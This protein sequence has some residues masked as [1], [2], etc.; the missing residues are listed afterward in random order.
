MYAGAWLLLLLFCA[1]YLGFCFAL[2]GLVTSDTCWLLALGRLMYQT[3][4]VPQSDPLSFTLPLAA[5]VGMPLPFILHQW[6]FEVLLYGLFLVGKLHALIAVC[7]AA[8]AMAF[9]SVP[10]VICARANA[11]KCFV[12]AILPLAAFSGAIRATVRPEVCT[13]LFLALLLLTLQTMRIDAQ[14]ERTKPASAGR[15]RWELIIAAAAIEIIW[16]NCHSGFVLGLG[17]MLVY[18]LSFLTQDVIDKKAIGPATK[19]G[20]LAL[21]TA[22]L[23]T[24]VNP[25]GV[26]L[27]M[28]M[29]YLLF[30]S[31]GQG[32]TEMKHLEAADF[33]RVVLYPFFALLVLAFVAIAKSVRR[34]RAHDVGST[35][36]VALSWKSP[37]PM[38]SIILIC[39]ASFEALNC[40]RLIPVMA[41]LL[42]SESTA[43]VGNTDSTKGPEVAAGETT[44]AE[45]DNGGDFLL[46]GLF[47][48]WSETARRNLWLAT[49]ALP[50]VVATL[51]ALL[52]AGKVSSLSLPQPS[53]FFN[54]P[55]RAI[56]FLRQHPPQGP[57]FNEAKIGSMIT[58]YLPERK[59]FLDTRF[60]EYGPMLLADY[61]RILYAQDNCLPTLDQYGIDWVFVTPQAPIAVTLEHV[62]GW[63]RV[64]SDNDAVIFVR[65]DQE[66]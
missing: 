65:K 6:L 63:Q 38:A 52:F 50:P 42:L 19:T 21:V 12:Y 8:L 29:P 54:P 45:D 25:A 39:A 13:C 7:S 36:G 32:I 61:N 31:I 62:G 44:A 27:W 48:G 47:R 34:Q 40:M 49:I 11:P 43:L 16:C 23:V 24:L 59:V 64:Y 28:F 14:K 5:A 3:H 56:E 60:D 51:S 35:D 53:E 30:S 22:T 41:L 18:A 46:V 4:Y 15:L 10:L 55:V 57:V 66:K 26:G 2:R 33:G 37:L 9:V 58:W 1:G 17:I 20:L